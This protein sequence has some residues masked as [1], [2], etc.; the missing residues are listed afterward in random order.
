MTTRGNEKWLVGHP[1]AEALHAAV[2][3]IIMEL[4]RTDG[5]EEWRFDAVRAYSDKIAGGGELLYPGNKKGETAELFNR[6][7]EC[8]AIL[9]FVPGG[10]RFAGYR[11]EATVE[12]M[13]ISSEDDRLPALNSEPYIFPSERGA[14]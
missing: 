14:P 13:R 5:P 7:A 8:L 12:K 10:V 3:L 11:F 4:Q 9:A 1:L 2:P 6:F